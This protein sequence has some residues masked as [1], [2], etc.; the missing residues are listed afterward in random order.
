MECNGWCG[1]GS[2]GTSPNG[3]CRGAAR[4]VSRGLVAF[5]GEAALNKIL[6]INT[7]VGPCVIS[8]EQV[9]CEVFGQGVRCPVVG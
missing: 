7:D 2:Y 4:L 6:N 9:E 5:A 8:S 3:L 1:M